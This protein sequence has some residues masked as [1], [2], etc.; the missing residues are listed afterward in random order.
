[1]VINATA[2]RWFFEGGLCCKFYC[3]TCWVH[4]AYVVSQCYNAHTVI[5]I[6][7]SSN[8]TAKEWGHPSSL[9]N[10]NTNTTIILFQE[11]ILFL[12][13]CGPKRG[14][15]TILRSLTKPVK[16]HWTDPMLCYRTINKEYYWGSVK[17]IS[18]YWQREKMQW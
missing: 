18:K 11:N 15:F 12:G 4:I 16:M 3:K 13:I 5:H 6:Q 2:I 14:M 17:H 1:M 10:Q 8:G 9:L 7:V